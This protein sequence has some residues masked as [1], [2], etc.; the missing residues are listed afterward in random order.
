MRLLA[1]QFWRCL[2]IYGPYTDSRICREMHTKSSRNGR[3]IDPWCFE[4]REILGI[5]SPIDRSLNVSTL[6][7]T[8]NQKPIHKYFER[9]PADQISTAI[10]DVE[11][12]NGTWVWW[13]VLA[14]Q[15]TSWPDSKWLLF[16]TICIFDSAR[17]FRLLSLIGWIWNVHVAS[18]RFVVCCVATLFALLLVSP[19]L[20]LHQPNMIC[21]VILARVKDTGSNKAN[22]N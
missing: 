18:L 5:P 1:G 9:L 10:W 13:H 7:K 19:C 21:I 15:R 4:M 11:Q 20:N 12:T 16:E 8:G 2:G 17:A 6:L 3:K 22:L 14:T